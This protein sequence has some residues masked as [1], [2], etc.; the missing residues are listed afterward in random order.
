MTQL[1]EDVTL[2]GREAIRTEVCRIWDLGILSNLDKG[3][4]G[5]IKALSGQRVGLRDG[6]ADIIAL[7]NTV[8]S[9]S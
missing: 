9:L 3:F 7:K 1:G 4:N 8:L 2:Y 5:D 6:C